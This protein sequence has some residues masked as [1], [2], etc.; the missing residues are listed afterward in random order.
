MEKLKL[1]EHE[2]TAEEIQRQLS[3]MTERWN[4]PETEMMAQSLKR[5]ADSL[6]KLATCIET[7]KGGEGY[8]DYYTFATCNYGG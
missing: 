3:E 6:E 1:G 8:P 2:Y 4:N 7:N 5:I